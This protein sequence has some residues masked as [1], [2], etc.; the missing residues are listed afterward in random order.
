MSIRKIR[1]IEEQEASDV[2][3]LPINRS[4]FNL[5]NMM[6]TYD[7]KFSPLI[8]DQLWLRQK[9]SSLF[10]TESNL[11]YECIIELINSENDLSV[12]ESELVGLIGFQNLEFVS[13]IIL[14]KTS[15]CKAMNDSESTPLGR[16]IVIHQSPRKSQKAA[17]KE[18]KRIASLNLYKEQEL[19]ISDLERLSK[20][21]EVKQ[22]SY[23]N[24]FGRFESSPLSVFGGKFALPKGT[25][26]VNETRYEEFTVPHDPQNERHKMFKLVNLDQFS[27]FSRLAFTGY[28]SLN[29][30]QSLVYPCAYR[31]R[32]NLLVCAPT[33]A[34]KTDVAMMTIL[35]AVEEHIIDN[36]LENLKMVYVAP[37][38]ALAAEVTRKFSSRLQPLKVRVREYTGDM[39]LTKQEIKS[40]NMIVT[41]PEKWD[42]ITRKTL[43][44]EDLVE[45]VKLLIIDEVHLLHDSRGHV[46]ESI[47]SRTLREAEMSQRMIRIV[48][49]SAT[50]PNFI[51]VASFLRVNLQTGMFYFD[52]S[53]RPV[54]LTQKFIGV[55]GKNIPVVNEFTDEICYEKVAE[56]VKRGHQVMVFVHSRNSTVKTCKRLIEMAK[57]QGEL[58][59]FLPETE[60]LSIYKAK[61]R[62]IKDFGS[63]GF[64][65]HHAGLLRSDRNLI[66]S[67]FAAGG[68]KVLC[69]TATLAWG[70]NLPA[71]AV[72]IKGT[73]VYDESKG[74]FVDLGILDVL[75]IFGRA[76]RPQFESHG[77]G[78]I[79]TKHEKLSHYLSA[80]TT[81]V[82]IESQ[83]LNH[84]PDSLNAEI[85]LGTISSVSDAISWICYTYLYVRIRKNPMAY[86]ISYKQ[87]SDEP[88]LSSV[89][90]K[91]ILEAA[92]LLRR[93]G[94]IGF[95][96]RTELMKIKD[97]GRISSVFYL[98]YETITT[99]KE[100]L[101]PTMTN[102]E[103]LSMIAQSSEFKNLKCRESELNAIMK[104]A[105]D[106]K[107]DVADPLTTIEG[108]VNV[109]IQTL[110]SKQK[111]NDF[112]LISDL[113]YVG[114]NAGR[115]MRAVFE[116][117]VH[118]SW[119]LAAA[120]TLDICKC[121]ELGVFTRDNPL[122]QLALIPLDVLHKL[123]NVDVEVMRDWTVGEIGEIARNK[124]I[125]P[126]IKDAI[127]QFPLLHIEGS[128]HPITKSVLRISVNV[129]VDFLW[130]DKIH[131]KTLPFWL[132]V[133]DSC[134]EFMY[135]SEHF[136]FN[137][138]TINDMKAFVFAIPVAEPLPSQIYVR[139]ISEKY[140]QCEVVIP[141]SFQ[142]LI[143]PEMSPVTTEL[144]RL[145]PLHIS[146]LKN[147]Q[148]EQLYKDFGT[149]NAIQTQAFHSL[150][151]G[152]SN[153]LVGA[154]TGSGKTIIAE[155][156]MWACFRD[157]PGC[158]VVYIAPLKALVKEKVKDWTLTLTRLH[159][160]LV[161]L[162]GDVTPDAR[163][164]K[165]ADV[166]ITT[167]EKWD[168]ISRE[169][170]NRNYVQQVRLLIIDEIH[171][172][173]TDR[174]P[175]LEV[176]ASRSKYI[177]NSLGFR[178]R[179]VGLSTA[180]ANA[181]DLGAWLNIDEASLFN[182]K[183]SCRPVPLEVRI[184]GF[185]GRHYCP[186][187]AT[188]NKPAFNAIITHSPEKPVIVFVSSRRQ[189]RLTAQGL[190]TYAAMYE[191]GKKF[192]RMDEDTL[193]LILQSVSDPHLRFTLGFGVGLH[194]AGLPENERK[195]VE[196]LFISQKIQVLVATSTLA[197]GVNFPAHLVIIK[198]TEF[199]D[200]KRKEYVD[201]PITDVLQMMGRAGRPQF[202]TSG[203]ACIFV[204]EN[205]KNFYKKFLYEPFPVESEL[206]EYLVD[207]INA[208]IVSGR[209]QT[210]DDILDFIKDTFFYRRLQINPFYYGEFDDVEVFLTS[211]MKNCLNELIKS[212][213]VTFEGKL[214]SMYLGKIAS[215]YYIS[216]LTVRTFNELVEADMKP[217]ALLQLISLAT[218]FSEVP[219]RHNEDKEL[220]EYC[221]SLPLT[222][223]DFED[224]HSKTLILLT[225]H[226]YRVDYNIS[227]FYT[228]LSSILDQINR[229]MQALLDICLEKNLLSTCFSLIRLMQ[230]IKIGRY[231]KSPLELIPGTHKTLGTD[232]SILK[233]TKLSYNELSKLLKYKPAIEF[234]QSL[235]RVTLTVKYD[236][237]DNEAQIDLRVKLSSSKQEENSTW[238]L[239]LE[240][241][242]KIIS[243][244]R[245][246]SFDRIFKLKV[247]FRQSKK[248]SLH[249]L[250][251]S[252]PGLEQEHQ[253]TF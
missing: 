183:P 46:I 245:V 57:E 23:P 19:T 146:A 50:L 114:Q 144:M 59:V 138:K 251:D 109:L 235:P 130:N 32:E 141:L 213:C 201:F 13:S 63:Q 5:R 103:I 159:L 33:G 74:D 8:F 107:I 180:L 166:I 68:L 14:N 219:V 40:T 29:R 49:L 225:G 162:T 241:N 66:E 216:H 203:K 223:L 202:D 168:G 71:H 21:M 133:E 237:P 169:W 179:I 250:N 120:R 7:S 12:L 6:N 112:S 128:I 95:D 3:F 41:T 10:K 100:Q 199:F 226:L 85:N 224:P 150:Y 27:E 122:K 9:C 90:R 37:M 91:Y 116:I 175:I 248:V 45:K 39:S 48:G 60:N 228:D 149:F 194:H 58:S 163:A 252:H 113:N 197:W 208:E 164:I 188:M 101:K 132:W 176:I 92:T 42:V 17:K 229:V 79:I 167:P 191:N 181:Q 236:R 34:G 253:F 218:E 227:D 151:Y 221:K 86:G 104:L 234:I 198:G 244:Q 117:C 193:E 4:Q 136:I 242:G 25:Q 212:K 142:H 1:Q 80:I 217:E 30:M 96:E 220:T 69:C 157:N 154:P 161:E 65:I 75:Q 11:I 36:P 222:I 64:G 185:S 15:L 247:I 207:H 2:E 187:M 78:I 56:Y 155:I 70:V 190:I 172:L 215:Y 38:K 240:E 51:D 20:M 196:D 209:L 52:G 148:V 28:K 205:K 61:S 81:Q 160:K 239:I 156:A 53:F 115:I 145:R 177:G 231:F 165:S 22:E 178:I 134:N 230:I 84:L 99:F 131:G 24:V 210:I 121:I 186:R 82:P 77:E 192:L 249:L 16:N 171:L 102:K 83:F 184:E 189:T 118:N 62:E 124:K 44:D 174:G 123:P 94:Q 147:P 137:K 200:P 106:C 211:I 26:R 126:Q 232:N 204:Q 119:C 129:T 47:V 214:E 139:V 67:N 97:L 153:V 127:N 158:K 43:G 55:K 93:N 170:K 140:L 105:K 108:K 238:F 135:Y 54:P 125:A 206:K 246:F 18:A 35:R 111:V 173:G 182:F 72:I 88:T 76:G 31:S 87:L 73:Q 98:N 110:I 143:L 243:F 233:L 152:K 89:V 195:L